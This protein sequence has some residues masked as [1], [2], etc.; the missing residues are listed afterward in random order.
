MKK[1]EPSLDSKKPKINDAKE[2]N[3]GNKNILKE[4]ILQVSLTV[5]WRCY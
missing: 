4:E 3:D 5:S 1:T 2:H